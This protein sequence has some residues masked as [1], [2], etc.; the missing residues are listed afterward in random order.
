MVFP[1]TTFH[2][3]Q[4]VKRLTCSCKFGSILTVQGRYYSWWWFLSCVLMSSNTLPCQKVLILLL[5]LGDTSDPDV[6]LETDFNN[7]LTPPHVLWSSLTN[8]SSKTKSA[9]KQDL[10]KK[11]CFSGKQSEGP[12]RMLGVAFSHVVYTLFAPWVIHWT[13]I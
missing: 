8:D 3:A 12:S 9:S 2:G 5:N 4:R 1:L 13:T 7:I 11:S 6:R 10:Q